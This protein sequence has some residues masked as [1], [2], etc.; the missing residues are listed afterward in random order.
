[1]SDTTTAKVSK[2]DAEWKEQLTPEQYR[3]TR[4]HGTER[5]FTGP[6]WDSFGP[7]STAA[8]A[9]RAALPLRYQIRC[10][11]RLAELFRTG[12][13]GCGDRASRQLLRH[14]PYGDLLQQMRCTS[15]PRLPRWPAA[16]GAALLHQRTFDGV[17]AGEIGN[18]RALITTASYFPVRE[19]I[20]RLCPSQ[21]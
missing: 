6:Y 5:A 20:D 14:G 15:R 9:E 16:D 13:A 18:A 10:R 7:A 11:L 19:T 2:T 21:G 8:S 17:R 3:I 4:Q 1:M 12:L